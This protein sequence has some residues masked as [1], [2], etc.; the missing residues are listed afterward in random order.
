MIPVLSK[1][2]SQKDYRTF[3]PDEEDDMFAE[4]SNKEQMNESFVSS[5]NI[6]LAGQ[7]YSLRLE[8][9]ALTKS[10]KELISEN[11][12]LVRDKIDTLNRLSFSFPKVHFIHFKIYFKFILKKIKSLNIN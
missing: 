3:V 10:N 12:R 2:Q 5:Q 8:V 1:S 4:E 9:G 7:L 11:L 6:E